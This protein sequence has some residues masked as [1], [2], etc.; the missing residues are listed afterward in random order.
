MRYHLAPSRGDSGHN[1]GERRTLAGHREALIENGWLDAGH[2]TPESD[3]V[4]VGPEPG[5]IVDDGIPEDVESQVGVI[6]IEEIGIVGRQSIAHGRRSGTGAADFPIV[7]GFFRVSRSNGESAFGA[8][9][10]PITWHA[11]DVAAAKSRE[12]G[13]RGDLTEHRRLK[14]SLKVRRHDGTAKEGRAG[15]VDRKPGS[16]DRAIRSMV[17]SLT[18]GPLNGFGMPANSSNS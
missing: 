10:V 14:A 16:S 7:R 2:V 17:P 1:R 18:A 8:A 11:T 12:P 4:S 5:R 15:K 13:C 6:I 3:R 9:A